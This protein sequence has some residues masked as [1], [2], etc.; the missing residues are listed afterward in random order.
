M[1]YRTMMLGTLVLLSVGCN[2]FRRSPAVEMSAGD[3]NLNTRWHGTLASPATLAGAV[4]ISGS[5][6]MAPGSDART[7]SVRLDLAN[8]APGGEHPWGLHRG[9]CDYD[10]GLIGSRSDFKAVKVGRDGRADGSA[11][12]ALHTPTSGRYSVR[13]M[14]SAANAEMIVACANLAPPSM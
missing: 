5:A 12:V 13:V 3:S 9:Q 4:Q 2:P 8:A 10:E 6:T 11:R 14:A 1:S 7:T